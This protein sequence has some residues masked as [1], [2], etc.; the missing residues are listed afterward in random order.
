MLV[1]HLLLTFKVK[2]ATHVSS[3]GGS[4]ALVRI[5]IWLT[6]LR[7]WRDASLN[8]LL[9]INVTSEVMSLELMKELSKEEHQL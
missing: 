9:L 4:T 7:D 6:L 3:R 2:V 1:D 5:L 8:Q